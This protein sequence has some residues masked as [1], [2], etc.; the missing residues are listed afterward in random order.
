MR[1]G[2]AV[3]AHIHVARVI[4]LLAESRMRL[5]FRAVRQMHG[6]RRDVVDSGRAV[7]LRCGAGRDALTAAGHAA[8]GGR[9]GESRGGSRLPN[10]LSNGLLGITEASDLRGDA[11]M[12]S[13][14][15]GR[16]VGSGTLCTTLYGAGAGTASGAAASCATGTS[17]SGML[18]ITARNTGRNFGRAESENATGARPSEK[19]TRIR[20]ASN[21]GSAGAGAGLAPTT[22]TVGAGNIA[23]GLVAKT[24]A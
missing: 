10:S 21:I 23:S 17:A 11:A 24:L 2:R 22:T 1:R 18:S 16:G 15:A 14:P 12:M 3:H 7:V 19:L 20:R 5:E 4:H 9:E 6:A 13:I 8:V